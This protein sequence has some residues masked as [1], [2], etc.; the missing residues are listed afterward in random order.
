MLPAAPKAAPAF[1]LKAVSSPISFIKK[2]ADF[3]AVSALNKKS[4]K[5]SVIILSAAR[6]ADSPVE[7]NAIRVGFTATRKL[8][9]AVVRNRVKRRMREAARQLLPELGTS[10][11]DYVFIGRP[12]AQLSTFDNLILDVKH[13]LKRLAVLRTD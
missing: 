5:P 1:L 8:G 7:E 3:L 12:Q 10:G 6:S 4:V 9:G 2:R 11:H 13:A